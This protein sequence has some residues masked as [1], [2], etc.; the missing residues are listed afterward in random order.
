MSSATASAPHPRTRS[1]I[2]VAAGALA[3]TLPLVGLVSLLMRKQLDPHFQNYRVHFVVFGLVGGIAWG[4]G[5]A[6][7]EAAEQRADARVLLLSLAFMAT[8]GFMLLHAVG[9]HEV[10]FSHQHA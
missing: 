7:G 4:L 2:G 1:T 8:G 6:A 3:F 9:T 5:F 10:L